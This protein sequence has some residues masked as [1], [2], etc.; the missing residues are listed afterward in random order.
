MK[1]IYSVLL[2]III[3]CVTMV[4][5]TVVSGSV[6]SKTNEALEGAV[7]LFADSDSIVGGTTTNSKGH[8]QLKN[9]PAGN[10]ECRVS[11]L[12]Y[13]P[14]SL[15]FKLTNKAKLPKFILDEDAKA[16]AEVT[17]VGDT[18]KMTKELAGM[19]IYYLSDRAKSEMDAYSALQEIPRLIVNPG[20]RTLTLDNGTT[21]LILVNGVKKPLETLLPELI[22]SVE[23][24][25]NPSARYLG[26][27][28]VASVLNIKLKKDGI[29]PY[30]K[31]NLVVKTTP[32]TNFIYSSGAFEIGSETSSLYV[33]GGYMQNG[34]TRAK[35]YSD[36]YQGDIHREQSGKS[37]STWR[38]PFAKIG[39]D[40][41]PT[42]KDYLAFEI[43][44]YPNPTNSN[45]ESEGH[46]TDMATGESSVL[47]SNYK[48]NNQHH[49]VIGNVNYKHLFNDTRILEFTGNYLFT[50]TTSDARR[51][52][53]SDLYNY[54]SNVDLHNSRHTGK[55]DINYSDMLSRSIQL[56]AGSNTEHTVTNIDD[57][58]DNQPNF[59]YRNTRE[60]LYAGI[61]NNMSGSKFNYVISLGL[62]MVFS[63]AS[64]AKHNYIDLVPSVSL[65]YK[66]ARLHNI[67]LL[68]QRS[69]YMPNA[70]TLNPYNT[71][72]D[73]L[74]VITGN[75]KLKPFHRDYV[76]FGYTF[77]NGKI[78]LNPYVQYRHY[79]DL[80]M[81]YDYLDGDIY[82]NSYR[83]YGN[84][85]TLQSGATFSYNTPQGKPYYAGVTLDVHYTKEYIKGMPFS[86][87]SY[88][89]Y[90]SMY[91]GYNKISANAYFGYDPS[92]SYSVYSKSLGYLSSQFDITWTF[93]QSFR[94]SV[95]AE[96]FICPRR[97]S[98]TWTV[99]GNFHS[100]SSSVQ[101]TLSPKICV[102]VSYNF[103]T[104]NF[105]W[106]N[107]KQFDSGD[108]ELK[109]VRPY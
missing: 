63:D 70:G 13:K 26:D 92:Y 45:S 30:L 10:Y 23:V 73:S 98:K 24:I 58:L 84:T 65:N 82:M 50:T 43:D 38:N 39:G 11:M 3:G 32:N 72:T 64:G 29:K 2:A 85:G 20:N 31:G 80:I 40:W 61:D 106:R 91:G 108:D 67:S 79:S 74:T 18:R 60:Y 99:N 83:N 48:S 27:T 1:R 89:G 66:L 102:G 56:Q 34:R 105:R 21:P 100:Y 78:R 22:E 52:Q 4:A 54:I 81:S 35:S 5:Q 44:Y 104:K 90:I 94:L 95:S 7:V 62:D 15:K 47:T 77:S 36:T 14:V 33:V 71:S 25:D 6:V 76:K 28:S 42:K 97:H 87:N 17:V 86:G 8:F 16:L 96:Q 88:G 107:K 75:P 109:S 68:Y 55:L 69:R 19:S 41:Q 51:E 46:I 59:C 103:V 53:N 9:L 49:Q 12:G 57:I 101:T 37:R 93:S